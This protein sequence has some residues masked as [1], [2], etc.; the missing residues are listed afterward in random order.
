MNS[1]SVPAPPGV[2]GP[3]ARSVWRKTCSKL[4]LILLLIG[5]STALFFVQDRGYFY[6]NTWNP[7]EHFEWLS[8][9]NLTVA[10]NYSFENHFLGFVNQ[11]VDAEDNIDYGVYADSDSNNV[12]DYRVYNRFPPGGYFLI[13]LVTL[14]FG[15]DL[16]NR[17]YAARILMLS[18]FAGTAA[19][20]YWSLCRLTH[21]RWIASAV[22]LTVLSS[23]QSLLFNDMIVPEL[24]PDLFGF[25]LA[26]HGMVIFTQEDR[27]RQLMVKSCIALLLGWHVLAM[28]LV[29]IILNLVKE[30]I[31]ARKI[32]SARE[33]FVSVITSRYF[34]LGVVALGIGILI[35]GYNIGN[36]YYAL[37]IRGGEQLALTDLPSIN[38]ILFRT[39]LS[40]ASASHFAIGTELLEGQLS[41]IGLLSI[42]F[43]FLGSSSP[44]LDLSWRMVGSLNLFVGIVVVGVCIIGLFLVRHRILAV[45]AVFAGIIWAI[46]MR[47]FAV[48]HGFDA[49]FY[50]GIPL[51]FYT[52]ILLL[53]RKLLSARLMPLGTLV[54]FLIFTFSNYR[55]GVDRNDEAVTFHESAIKDF[56][57]IREFTGGKSVF[58]PVADTYGEM[59]RLVGAAYGLQYYLSGSNIVFENYGCDR[60][61]DEID[62]LLRFGYEDT[63]DLLTPDNQRFFLSDRNIYGQRIDRL[64]QADKPVVQSDFDVYLTDDRK[65]VYVGDRCVI[66]D[67]GYDFVVPVSLAIYPVKAEDLAD[68]GRDHELV[69]LNYIEHSVVDANRYVLI[70]DLPHYEIDIISTWQYADDSEIWGG[71]FFG[72]EH[73]VDAELLQKVDR[74]ATSNGPTIRNHFDIYVT[75]ER[76]LIY[77]RSP[78]QNSDISVEF[79]LHVFPNDIEDLPEHRGQHLFDNYDFD[80]ID[81]GTWDGQRC[82]AEIKL[83]S[84]EV[85]SILT[86]Q[87]ADQSTIWQDEIQYHSAVR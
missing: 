46:V 39:G 40:Q 25:A 26:F 2:G 29:F 18:L 10:V 66:N 27:F 36:E 13:K 4:P 37:N 24:G 17:I 22:T 33:I 3:V 11:S 14:P 28:L 19:L 64:V 86:G 78:C 58:V 81:Y 31:K 72:P 16:S 42:P 5:M 73:L 34:L 70:Y 60:N 56:S 23:T 80:F 20:A 6:R 63:P 35:L 57:V 79:F 8:S 54:A 61:W 62:Y 44:Y 84:Y 77:V 15:D 21:N 55:M 43:A 50:A 48:L 87:F 71:M 49:L 1:G 53:M 75:D 69:T 45:T 74:I 67:L 47:R 76:S 85:D 32:L 51:F 68:T 41:R 12:S 65:L 7:S 9:H 52:L 30:I 38:S 59:N 83:P 82:V